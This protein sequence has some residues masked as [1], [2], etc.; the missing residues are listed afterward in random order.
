MGIAEFILSEDE[1]LD[2]SYRKLCNQVFEFEFSNLLS[3]ICYSTNDGRRFYL[4]LTTPS[5]AA[6]GGS[7]LT[8]GAYA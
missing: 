4:Y 2:P 5:P 6:M 7:N 3:A 8:G 1:G